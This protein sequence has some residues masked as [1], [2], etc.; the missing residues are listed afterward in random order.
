MGTPF[1]SIDDRGSEL[2]KMSSI[3]DSELSKISSL[4]GSELSKLSSIRKMQVL[5]NNVGRHN[6]QSQNQHNRCSGSAGHKKGGGYFDEEVKQISDSI[7]HREP[8]PSKEFT[9]S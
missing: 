3:K 6:M 5:S 7:G 4:R 8:L 9:F 2:S 1:Q